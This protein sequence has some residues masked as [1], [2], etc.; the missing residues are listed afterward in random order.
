M[1][2]TSVKVVW[3]AVEN[4]KPMYKQ[5][6]T[7]WQDKGLVQL[8]GLINSVII[9]HIFIYIF[10]LTFYIYVY[11]FIDRPISLEMSDDKNECEP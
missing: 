9:I 7:Y 4:M 11:I 6:K 5:T 2:S 3:S 8:N 1:L 10:I